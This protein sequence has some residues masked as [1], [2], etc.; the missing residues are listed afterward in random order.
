V[1]ILELIFELKWMTTLSSMKQHN[2]KIR[3]DER[4]RDQDDDEPILSN[5]DGD[6]EDA[7]DQP[8]MAALTLEQQKAELKRRIMQPAPKR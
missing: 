4:Y 1:L 7:A 5:E 2:I 3:Y 8:G 6:Y